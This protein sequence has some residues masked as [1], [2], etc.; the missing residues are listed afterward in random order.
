[1][2]IWKGLSS[3]LCNVTALQPVQISPFN[4]SKYTTVLHLNRKGDT[5]ETIKHVSKRK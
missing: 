4:I 3:A 2:G 1:M 5:T